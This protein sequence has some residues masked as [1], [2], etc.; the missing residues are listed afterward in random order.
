MGIAGFI[1]NGFLLFLNFVGFFLLKKRLD[2]F[3]FNRELGI[4][5]FLGFLAVC[6]LFLVLINAKWAWS[7]GILVYSFM[8]ANSAYLLYLQGMS[9]L[10]FLVTALNTFSFVVAILA[11]ELSTYSSFP[12]VP[13][14]SFGQ[15]S[16][17]EVYDVK[18]A[19]K[20]EKNFA[21]EF[22]TATKTA[23]KTKASKKP[24]KRKAKKPVKKEAKSVKKEVTVEPVEGAV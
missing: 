7:F 4:L 12:N 16:S 22:A 23:T 1:A 10:L 24:T 18:D 17:V 21:F 19:L 9:I 6:L 14:A 3:Y 8:L 15:R 5:V 2:E 20:S 13:S 11:A